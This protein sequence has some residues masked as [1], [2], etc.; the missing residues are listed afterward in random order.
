M[1][2]IPIEPPKKV[3]NVHHSSK[4]INDNMPLTLITGP[5]LGTR[6]FRKSIGTSFF[7]SSMRL[8]GSS[9]SN[10]YDTRSVHESSCCVICTDSA[11][12]TVRLNANGSGDQFKITGLCGLPDCLPIL[13]RVSLDGSNSFYYSFVTKL[14]SGTRD[15]G[16]FFEAVREGSGRARQFAMTSRSENDF[17]G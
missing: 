4:F 5:P 10:V 12:C 14:E 1:H 15:S 9:G 11:E 17:N 3:G 13:L 7:P 8:T 2:W 6:T 16:I